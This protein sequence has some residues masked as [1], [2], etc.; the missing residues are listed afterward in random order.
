VY[1]LDEC[2]DAAENVAADGLAGDDA[3]PRFDLIEPA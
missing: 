2:F 3:E 1:L